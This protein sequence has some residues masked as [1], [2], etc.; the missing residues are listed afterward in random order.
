MVRSPLPDTVP[1]STREFIRS[2]L[3]NEINDT[4]L[5][6]AVLCIESP[7]DNFH[8]FKGIRTDAQTQTSA[9]RIINRDAINEIPNLHRPTAADMNRTR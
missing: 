4:R 2:D 1:D 6:I 7:R 5:C 3:R 9:D 8:L